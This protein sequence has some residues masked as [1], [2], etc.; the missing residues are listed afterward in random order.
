M[1][2]T[3]DLPD[4]LFR[5]AKAEAALRGQKFKD[6]L[7]EGLRLILAGAPPGHG[8]PPPKK[9]PSM[10]DLAK[11]LIFEGVDSPP[12]LSTNPKYFDDFGR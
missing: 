12:D 8:D 7:E 4:D 5:R 9:K 6:L 11:D 3:I 10:H 2:T 1:R